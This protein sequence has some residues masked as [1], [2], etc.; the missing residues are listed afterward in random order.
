MRLPCKKG[1]RW[2]NVDILLKHVFR[3]IIDKY[4]TDLPIQPKI[5]DV[6]FSNYFSMIWTNVQLGKSRLQIES[7]NQISKC[8]PF[9]DRIVIN[10]KRYLKLLSLNGMVRLLMHQFVNISGSSLT[11]R[12]VCF[13]KLYRYLT[14]GEYLIYLTINYT[15]FPQHWYRLYHSNRK[16]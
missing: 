13:T 16:F 4:D 15:S 14:G 9:P 6:A 3:N 5:Y 2:Y 7:Q 12:R 1:Y 10:N 8:F 11:M